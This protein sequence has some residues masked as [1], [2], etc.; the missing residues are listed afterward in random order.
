MHWLLAGCGR[1]GLRV[2]DLLLQGG[3]RVTGLRRHWPAEG[4]P[5]GL[6]RC[7]VDLHDGAALAASV[8]ADVDG[9]IHVLTPD[10]RSPEG[11]RRAYLS[12]LQRLLDL[13][14][15]AADS[16]RW[17]FVSSTAVYGDADGGEVD[18]HTVPAPGR[19]NGAVLAQAE[20]LLQR[21]RER[22]CL[23]RLGG[24]YGP[25]RQ[26][27]ISQLRLGQLRVSRTQPRYT[28]RIHSTDAARLMGTLCTKRTT[29]V[30]NGVDCCPATDAEVADW[31]A[32]RLGW[33]PA[34]EVGPDSEA[35]DNKR[36]RSCRLSALPFYH[37]YPDY[38]S[39]YSAALRADQKDEK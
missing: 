35:R 26:Y 8:P 38:R 22:S 5:V 36:I 13:P 3:H 18:E 2:A 14:Q 33:P 29:G 6:Q 15:L 30:I 19:F 24:I 23:L 10:E 1:L 31:L 17:L 27:L 34:P 21:W 11:Y 12:S 16:Q 37:R 9:I 7:T 39:G 28:N 32:A 20:Q 4:I 25:G